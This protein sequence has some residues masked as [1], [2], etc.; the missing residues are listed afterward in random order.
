VSCLL[1]SGFVTLWK[2]VPTFRIKSSTSTTSQNTTQATQLHTPEYL[3]IELC[4]GKWIVTCFNRVINWTGLSVVKS[5]FEIACTGRPKKR[6]P[7]ILFNLR[8]ANQTRHFIWNQRSHIVQCFFCF[9]LHFTLKIQVFWD[10]TP[11]QVVVT[12]LSEEPPPSIYR[13]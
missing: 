13:T 12:G 6:N 1:Y 5:I 8:F 3:N 10:M 2:C 4:A 9:Y 7:N 11:C